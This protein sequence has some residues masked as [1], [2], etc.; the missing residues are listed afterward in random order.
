M[1]PGSKWYKFDIHT[2]TP[3]SYDYAKLDVDLKNRIRP[4]EWLYHFIEK[5]IQCIA[6]TDHNSGAA[7]DLYKS[8]AEDLRN[9]GIDITIFPGVEISVQ[10]GV[11]ILAIFDP[12]KT[13]ADIASLLGAVQYHSE[14]GKTDSVTECSPQQVIKMIHKYDGVAIPAHI[15]MDAGYCKELTGKTLEQALTS[16]D[17][18]EV[19]NPESETLKSYR[20]YN[21]DI[22]ELLGSDSH[23]PSKVGRKFSWL[24]MDIPDISGLK[25]ALI[26]GASSVIRSDIVLPHSLNEAPACVIN[27]LHV[28]NTKY[29]GTR[30]PLEINFNPWLNSIIGGRGTGK[31]SLIE[32]MRIALDRETELSQHHEINTAFRNATRIP[33]KKDAPGLFKKDTKISINYTKNC[34]AYRI[35]WT[36]Q[37]TE[38]HKQQGT[39]WIAEDGVIAERFPIRIFSQKQIFEISKNT[40]TLLNLIDKS[41]EIDLANWIISLKRES[42]NYKNLKN[43]ISQHCTEIANKSKFEGERADILSR[44]SQI[45]K[46]SD[47]PALALYRRLDTVRGFIRG[48]HP[49]A[50][51]TITSTL[52]SIEALRPLYIPDYIKGNSSAEKEMHNR[53]L[54]IDNILI[55]SKEQTRKVMENALNALSE[56]SEWIDNSAFMQKI[57]DTIPDVQKSINVENQLG[58]QHSLQTKLENIEINLAKIKELEDQRY[59]LSCLLNESEGNLIKIRQLIT[60]RRQCFI[61]KYFS[62][63]ESICIRILPFEDVSASLVTFSQI[64]EEKK[65]QI[66]FNVDH[67]PYIKDTIEHLIEI[68][69]KSKNDSDK[70]KVIKDFKKNLLSG[71]TFGKPIP[72]HIQDRINFV[73]GEIEVNILQWFPEDKL[74]VSF[75]DQGGKFR[76]IA[77]ASAGQRSAAILSLI[78]S[79]GSEPLILDQPEDDLDNKL[80]GTLIV[81]RLKMLKTRRQVIIVTHNANIVVNGDSEL[82]IALVNIKGQSYINAFGGLQGNNIKKHVCEIM[83]GGRELFEK[84]YKR[85]LKA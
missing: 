33:E 83:E 69:K 12:S 61:S 56:F 63:I 64:F 65:R 22:P 16:V 19:I 71:T 42:N 35:T 32:F 49:N 2:H 45:S 85:I 11:H 53:L 50:I 60:T 77:N 17:A 84:R 27:T 15:D 37:K 55:D 25:N 41:E 29:L 8:A 68:I 46:L 6:I 34:E 81:D 79:L 76:S 67:H 75:K 18:V 39:D 9:E 5:G 54:N 38:I 26:D 24:K 43:T 58:Q 72:S 40:N 78:L 4:T 28:E 47:N 59:T 57:Y 48:H 66:N 44:I 10:G 30:E 3:Y 36:H 70:I 73:R 23:H 82:V 52:K 74:E 31:S 1:V 7:I 51:S 21:I 62:G 13:S 14:Y 20:S 80:I